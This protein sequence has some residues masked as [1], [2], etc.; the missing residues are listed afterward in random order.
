MSEKDE[1]G[2]TF[3][4]KE[5]EKIRKQLDKLNKEASDYFNNQQDINKC[6]QEAKKIYF[7]G[8]QFSVLLDPQDF[9]YFGI[10]TDE[11]SCTVSSLSYPI[12]YCPFCG[13]E[14]NKYE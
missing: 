4:L 10:E 7:N 9:K 2:I 1:S 5:I 14:L 6:C 12:K 3:Q 8:D 13:T 11:N